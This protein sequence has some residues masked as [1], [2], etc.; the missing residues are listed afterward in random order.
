MRCL[1]CKQVWLSPHPNHITS[2]CLSE[3]PP[4]NIRLSD[5]LPFSHT[6]SDTS[7]RSE[8]PSIL[9]TFHRTSTDVPPTTKTSTP[10]RSPTHPRSSP[11]KGTL[12][13]LLCQPLHTEGP[14]RSNSV[15]NQM[16]LS[17]A[18][19][20]QQIITSTTTSSHA[21]LS[22]QLPTSS[23]TEHTSSSTTSSLN[24][25]RPP[26]LSSS[27]TTSSRSS[28]SST[29]RELIG[30]T[31]LELSRH[32][33]AYDY[34]SFHLTPMYLPPIPDDPPPEF[35][36]LF[37][38]P[39]TS[40][41]S[42]LSYLSTH[43]SPS[44]CVPLSVSP[45]RATPSPQHSTSSSLPYSPS[46]QMLLSLQFPNRTSTIHSF[47]Q[48]G[49]FR[50]GYPVASSLLAVSTAI[51]SRLASAFSALVRSPCLLSSK[52]MQR[53]NTPRLYT[54]FCSIS[55]SLSNTN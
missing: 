41:S 27:A 13:A 7:Q 51:L 53:S 36:R 25:N 42:P 30:Q 14:T 2:D 23:G 26:Q 16:Q 47:R 38:I 1:F 35:I 24:L 46:A 18:N 20:P 43:L 45:Q 28:A 52:Q 22:S 40:R 31:A 37:H 10:P 15:K 21:S 44:F 19:P 29:I 48:K 8:S 39:W 6:D 11:Q 55:N 3:C 12:G 54:S 50:L 32:K 5:L 4:L 49:L 17:P 9:H 34:H 33:G